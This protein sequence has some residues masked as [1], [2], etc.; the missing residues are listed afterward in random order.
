MRIMVKKVGFS[1]EKGYGHPKGEE[2]NIVK[3]TYPLAPMKNGKSIANLEKDQR[4]TLY[5]S[6]ALH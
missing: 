5:S 6:A 4:A 1:T 3:F 2:E